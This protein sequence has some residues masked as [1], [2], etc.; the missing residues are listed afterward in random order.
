[1]YIYIEM[2]NDILSFSF[3][4][5]SDLYLQD[6]VVGLEED[7]EGLKN[8]EVYKSRQVTQYKQRNN[9]ATLGYLESK[10]DKTKHEDKFKKKPRF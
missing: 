9:T 5:L 8:L 3:F 10:L 1:M 2:F 4:I 7:A 6:L